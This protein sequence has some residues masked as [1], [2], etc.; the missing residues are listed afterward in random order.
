MPMPLF[1]IGVS[2]LRNCIHQIVHLTYLIDTQP[3]IKM[4]KLT[5]HTKRTEVRKPRRKAGME[6]EEMASRQARIAA[7]VMSWLRI[8]VAIAN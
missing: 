5:K 4:K 6:L 3:L 2:Q 7:A 8:S 1:N